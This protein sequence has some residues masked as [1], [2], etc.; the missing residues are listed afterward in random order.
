MYARDGSDD[1]TTDDTGR[2]APAQQRPAAAAA[3]PTTFLGV[4]PLLVLV[5]FFFLSTVFLAFTAFRDYHPE[6]ATSVT[7]VL[8]SN[9][10]L[11]MCAFV[12]SYLFY[13]ILSP[14]W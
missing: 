2:R 10:F 13:F 4:D 7:A 5:Q 3:R 14:R 6:R 1:T 11:A 8:T 12:I 9:H